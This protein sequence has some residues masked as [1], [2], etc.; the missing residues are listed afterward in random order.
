VFKKTYVV[1]EKT[2]E[3]MY[4]VIKKMSFAD[5]ANVYILYLLIGG[6]IRGLTLTLEE[7]KLYPSDLPWIHLQPFNNTPAPALLPRDF[8]PKYLLLRKKI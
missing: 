2:R 4:V 7:S 5:S 3:K 8:A 6:T 1:R